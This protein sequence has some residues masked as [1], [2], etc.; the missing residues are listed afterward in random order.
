VKAEAEG[1]DRVKISVADTG[2][3][4]KQENLNRLFEAFRQIDGSARR[5]FEGTGLG[6]HLVRK[7]LTM[8]GGTVEVSSEFG[9]GSVF[10]VHIPVRLPPQPPPVQLGSVWQPPEKKSP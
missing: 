4:I 6:L 9:V 10:T 3:G 8:L 1:P 2:I 7:L 5:V